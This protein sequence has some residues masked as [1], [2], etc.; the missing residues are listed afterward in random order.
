MRTI[1]GNSSGQGDAG[2]Q[3]TTRAGR[4][5]R[6]GVPTIPLP[7]DSAA[8]AAATGAALHPAPQAVPAQA[9]RPARV[10]CWP[11][12][13]PCPLELP[14]MVRMRPPTRVADGAGRC[15]QPRPDQLV[16]GGGEGPRLRR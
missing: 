5:A 12:A 6:A 7:R 8:A 2:G 13:S 15:R 3:Q 1:D 14:S 4:A 11:L 10:V 9:A 16:T